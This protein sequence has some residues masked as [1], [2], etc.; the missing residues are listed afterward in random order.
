[1]KKINLLQFASSHKIGLT[2]QEA[3]LAIEYTNNLNLNLTIISGENEQFKGLRQ[4]IKI[5]NINHAVIQGLD[6]HKHFLKLMFLIRDILIKNEIDIITV[7]TNWQLV[8]A[9][10][11]KL[12]LSKKISIVYTIHGYR[13]NEFIKS[14]VARML[15]GIGLMLFSDKVNT[16][17]KFL[18][19]KFSF[20]G[21]KLITIPL[22][23]EVIFFE[24]TR[25]RVDLEKINFVFPGVFRHGKNHKVLIDIFVK[26]LELSGLSSSTLTLPGDGPLLDSIRR[27]VAFLNL[28]KNIILP[29]MLNRDEM[30]KVY[31]SNTVAIMPSNIETF[32]HA[33]VEP[34]IL[35]NV[36]ITRRT[37]IAGEIIKEGINGFSFLKDKEI[38][39]I[40]LDI[41]K[42]SK[43]DLSR[44]SAAASESVKS[45]NWQSI[46]KRHFDEI[47]IPLMQIN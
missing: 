22:G 15:I 21:K 11:S 44:I 20:L 18:E 31:L 46:A 42:L 1:M 38:L 14:I 9:W 30:I 2:A 33:I 37:G 39:K 19:K 29:G 35:G 10:F 47:F 43:S 13:H 45:F 36:L 6:E 28:E 34:L 3:S 40:M 32:G 26:F 4:N 23:E 41:T 8:C 27:Y 12:F 25:N 16:P 17:S 5:R 7:N 24:N